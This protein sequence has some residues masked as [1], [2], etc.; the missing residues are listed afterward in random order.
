MH[1]AGAALG[2]QNVFPP[3]AES[4]S[5]VECPGL[6]VV[7]CRFVWRKGI[8]RHLELMGQCLYIKLYHTK[9]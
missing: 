3:K 4:V 9:G 5:V 6:V 7:L 8:V 1:N 2:E